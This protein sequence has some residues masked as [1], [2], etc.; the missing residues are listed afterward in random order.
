ME[1]I[2]KK[3]IKASENHDSRSYCRICKIAGAC[4]DCGYCCYYCD[5]DVCGDCSRLF[6]TKYPH[7]FVDSLYQR[8]ICIQCEGRNIKGAE[9][10][11]G[12]E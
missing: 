2:N 11:K 7:R 5:D 12:H 9:Y 4:S 8:R 3:F 6:Y 10:D 1:D